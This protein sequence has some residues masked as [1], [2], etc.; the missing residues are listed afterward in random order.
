MTDASCHGAARPPIRTCVGCRAA[1][2]QAELVRIAVV[3]GRL[4]A[5]PRRRA[6]GRGAYLHAR[7]ACVGGASKG[8][9]RSLKRA[10]SRGEVEALARALLPAA[11]A[12]VSARADGRRKLA[13]EVQAADD[14]AAGLPGDPGMIPP[15][16]QAPE[17]V[18]IGSPSSTRSM[19]NPRLTS[20]PNDVSTPGP[21][22]GG[23]E[24]SRHQKIRRA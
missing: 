14:R 5:D 24:R 10:V 4:V 13:D 2:P 18:E 12:P 11:D 20:L 22:A 15:G 1:V 3:D 8:L 7:T 21:T 9:A 6:P 23:A 19:S 17:A 16:E